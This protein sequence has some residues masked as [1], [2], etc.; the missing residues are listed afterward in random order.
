V[1]KRLNKCKPKNPANRYFGAWG[2]MEKDIGI[3]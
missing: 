2:F 1:R 3:I